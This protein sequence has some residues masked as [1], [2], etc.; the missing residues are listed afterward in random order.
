MNFHDTIDDVHTIAVST[1]DGERV[2][3][4][5]VDGW[6]C[7]AVPAPTAPTDTTPKLRR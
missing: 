3:V 5:T 2:Y 4:L 7:Y 6:R 1:E